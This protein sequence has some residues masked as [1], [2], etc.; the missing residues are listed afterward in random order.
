MAVSK[1]AA[2]LA[3]TTL[4]LSIA[5]EAQLS[6]RTVSGV[7]TDARGNTLPK[8]AVQLENTATL[9]VRSYITTKDGRYMFRGLNGDVDYTLRAKYRTHWSKTKTLSKFNSSTHPEVNL[10]IPIE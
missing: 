4:F 2:I 1:K 8:V 5:C 7:V 9:R 10:T 6:T 3:A